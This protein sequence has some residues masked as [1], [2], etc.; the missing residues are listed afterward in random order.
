MKSLKELTDVQLIDMVCSSYAR[1]I[2]CTNNCEEKDRHY[3][4]AVEE[5]EIRL[6]APRLEWKPIAEAP[7]DTDLILVHDPSIKY[8]MVTFKHRGKLMCYDEVI[9][10]ST[11]T[12]YCKIPVSNPK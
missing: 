8:P 7:E 10:S 1:L 2:M 12:H 6:S 3:N 4:E 9:K 5:L 11:P